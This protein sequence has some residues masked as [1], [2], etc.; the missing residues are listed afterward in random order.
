MAI[1]EILDEGRASFKE[2]ILTNLWVTCK[3]SASNFDNEHRV[4]TLDIAEELGTCYS[5][6]LAAFRAY[7]HD[8]N[9]KNFWF[10]VWPTWQSANALLGAYQSIRMGFPHEAFVILRYVLESHALSACLLLHPE[11]LGNY[12]KGKFTGAQ[13]IGDLK[14]LYPAMAR[15]YGVI[16]ET[17]AHPSGV[18][19]GNFVHEVGP[20]TFTF[21]IGGG[22]PEGSS[23][24]VRGDTARMA[25]AMCGLNSSYLNATSERIAMP[26]VKDPIYWQRGKTAD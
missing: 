17:V 7:E 14:S 16:T 12:L 22:L 26:L 25:V 20:D 15:Q 4:E 18:T 8:D 23:G 13:R 19:A 21:L 3:H 24:F 1:Q 6:L 10:A 5:L 9:R 11:M 2:N